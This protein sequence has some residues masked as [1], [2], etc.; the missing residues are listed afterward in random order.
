M[1]AQAGLC[2]AWSETPEDTLCRVVAQ[3]F[4]LDEAAYSR[5]KGLSSKE[6][7]TVEEQFEEV[8]DTIKELTVTTRRDPEPPEFYKISFTMI[9][10]YKKY[11]YVCI[12]KQLYYGY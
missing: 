11:Q 3:M 6:A 5:V 12:L 2:L 7:V 9:K 4:E 1:A 10:K 8:E